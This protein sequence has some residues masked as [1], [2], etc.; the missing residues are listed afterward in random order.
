MQV[1]GLERQFVT[2]VQDNAG[3]SGKAP[4]A[5]IKEWKELMTEVADHQSLVG[6]LKESP[7]FAPFKEETS[8]WET[9]LATLSECCMHLNSVQRKWVYLEPIF[10]RGA[11]PQVRFPDLTNFF[12]FN[13]QKQLPVLLNTEQ[14]TRN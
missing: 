14:G 4:V 13:L 7:F 2:M 5:L 3:G 1:W 6:S 8:V 11:L 9:R 10:A 12:F